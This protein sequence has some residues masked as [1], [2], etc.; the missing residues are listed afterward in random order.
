KFTETGSVELA[1]SCS[2]TEI[3]FAV[4]DTGIGISVEQQEVIFDAFH[5]ADGQ[6]NRKY[7]GTGLGLSISRELARLLGGR[8][9]LQSEA[10]T[11]SLFTLIIPQHYDPA[12]VVQR[13]PPSAAGNA[14]PAMPAAPLAPRPLPSAPP[15]QQD[16]SDGDERED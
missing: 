7:G 4:R 11:G 15:E 8:I 14:V 13:P 3:S 12:L 16:A 10:G 1:I 9:T 2:D 5:Q 6:T